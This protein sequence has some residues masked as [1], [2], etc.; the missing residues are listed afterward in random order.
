MSASSGGSGL[1]FR[2]F[3]LVES[4]NSSEFGSQLSLTS[5]APAAITTSE[6]RPDKVGASMPW[7]PVT[8]VSDGSFIFL[9]PTSAVRHGGA[10]PRSCL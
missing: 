7:I 4:R 2:F 8:R 6:K 10:K 3:F 5:L 1:R 9:C